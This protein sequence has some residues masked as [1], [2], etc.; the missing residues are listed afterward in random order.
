MGY[1][2]ERYLFP[3]KLRLGFNVVLLAKIS[4][5][6]LSRTCDRFHLVD[7]NELFFRQLRYHRRKNRK[8]YSPISFQIALLIFLRLFIFIEE[9]IFFPSKFLLSQLC[10]FC[11]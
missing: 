1:S 7:S 9:N 2:T 5:A 8:L 6:E 4:A 11:L 3:S 10:V